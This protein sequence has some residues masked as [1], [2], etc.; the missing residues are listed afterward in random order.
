[1]GDDDDDMCSRWFATRGP[2]ASQSKSKHLRSGLAMRSDLSRAE[3]MQYSW[4]L[5]EMRPS[6]PQCRRPHYHL[7]LCSSKAPMT[8][9]TFL[10]S[11]L[12]SNKCPTLAPSARPHRLLVLDL[13]CSINSPC[14]LK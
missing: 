4:L 3:I 9:M 14:P 12:T 2:A 13:V 10:I 6:R 1:M 5:R 11:G 7:C 8:T